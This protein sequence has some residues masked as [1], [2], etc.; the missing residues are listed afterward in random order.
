MSDLLRESQDTVKRRDTQVQN[1]KAELAARDAIL[2]QANGIFKEL[3]QLYPEVTRV[4]LADGV[5]VTSEESKEKVVYITI[6]TRIA[7]SKEI[8]QRTEDWLKV[9]LNLNSI[10]LNF[11]TE[12][13]PLKRYRW[14]SQR[15]SL[16]SEN[17][18]QFSLIYL[19][20]LRLYTIYI[21]PDHV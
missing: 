14:L 9:R 4:L 18:S 13:Q 15:L 17:T 2:G 7:M 12:G 20:A 21:H 6:T 11:D 19:Q 16:H 3:R 5:S 1:L 8:H 10:V